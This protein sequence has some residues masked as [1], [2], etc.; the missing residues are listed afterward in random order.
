MEIPNFFKDPNLGTVRVISGTRCTEYKIK[1]L[2]CKQ[3]EFT[4]KYSKEIPTN[5]LP[6][7]KDGPQKYWQL[8]L[9]ISLVALN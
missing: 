9:K 3:A 7:S 8:I 1:P 6:N 2:N 4:T 5:R